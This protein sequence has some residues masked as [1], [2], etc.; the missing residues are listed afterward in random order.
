[1]KVDIE[2]IEEKGWTVT[3][4]DRSVNHLTYEEM[5]G[6]VIA[7]TMPDQRPCLGW[8]RTKAQDEALANYV[9]NQL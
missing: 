3:T 9:N 8:L 4:G 2:Y 5:L 7:A 1:M 6:V